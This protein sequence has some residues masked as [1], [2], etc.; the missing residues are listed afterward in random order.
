[1]KVDVR[2]LTGSK[3]RTR[4]ATLPIGTGLRIV[5]KFR[6]TATEQPDVPFDTSIEVHYSP[7]DGRYVIAEATF[8]ARPG[9]EVNA[10]RLRLARTADVLKASAP[11]CITFDALD[12]GH[13][14]KASEFALSADRILPPFIVAQLRQRKNTEARMDA[15]EIVYGVAA[16]SGLPP[17]QAVQNEMGIPHRTAADWISKARDAGRLEG[18][19]YVAGR[20]VDG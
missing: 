8:R 1:M 4:D 14:V 11:E 12:D 6:A 20:R 2:T 7:S 15:V 9:E 5:P 18:M 10:V 13:W 16:L 3:I 17:T 19:A